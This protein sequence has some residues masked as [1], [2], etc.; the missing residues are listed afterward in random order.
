MNS[1]FYEFIYIG[2]SGF[3]SICVVSKNR[4]VK[5]IMIE[6]AAVT[7]QMEE[8]MYDMSLRARLYRVSKG[9]G[10]GPAGLSER[11][12]LLLELIGLK[13]SVS[14]SEIVKLYVKASP[15][16]IST[17]ITR[18]WKDKKLVDKNIDPDNQRLTMVSLTAKGRAALEEIIR[19]R[20]KL[21]TAVT[22]SLGVAQ[23]EN[24]LFRTAMKNG[25]RYF[26]GILGL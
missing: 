7:K 17:T 16:T 3:L 1:T 13:G 11:E 19:A 4:V 8:L 23:E 9:L 15:S 14:I 18:L 24:S 10:E 6:G 12:A 20:S 21:Y 22:E 26:D 2:V 5:W 25:A